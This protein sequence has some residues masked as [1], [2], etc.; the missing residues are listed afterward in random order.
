MRI[1]NRPVIAFAP[2][3]AR[4]AARWETPIPLHPIMYA[5]TP[6]ICW[7]RYGLPSETTIGLFRARISALTKFANSRGA[8]ALVAFQAWETY[9][10]TITTSDDLATRSNRSHS[11]LDG[12]SAFT[13]SERTLEK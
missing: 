9:E 4:A 8:S 5:D 13:S 7:S 2:S 11:A 12:A 10:L 3:K 6:G 1:G